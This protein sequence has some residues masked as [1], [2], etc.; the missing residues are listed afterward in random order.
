MKK[1]ILGVLMT[2][3]ILAGCSGNRRADYIEAMEQ[4]DRNDLMALHNWLGEH[5]D[6][7]DLFNVEK[8]YLDLDG[9]DIDQKGELDIDEVYFVRWDFHVEGEDERDLVITEVWD[10]ESFFLS[11]A[12]A[13]IL[14]GAADLR[15]D[16]LEDIV[17]FIRNPDYRNIFSLFTN[18]QAHYD[19]EGNAV[20]GHLVFSNLV[21]PDT[22]ESWAVEIEDTTLIITIYHS[23]T[24]LREIEEE[25][26]REEEEARAR[27]EEEARAREEA[28]RAREEERAARP[29]SGITRE[30]YELITMGM[31]RD[32]VQALIDRRATSE[33]TSE[34]MGTT[35]EIV[36]WMNSSNF[37]SI[38]V[39]F[40]NGRV[41][42]I[43]W[44]SL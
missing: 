26:I 13:T 36:T 16:H 21:V 2:L 7:Y 12:T 38:T 3:L 23:A 43:S 9:N 6:I 18:R 28:E 41:S 22:F 20:S 14:E 10:Y 42:S 19:T 34:F 5:E 32:E 24:R 29:P 31:T 35:T 33:T 15:A 30:V 1:K 17:E 40:T 25:R 11:K 8:M 44:F 37:N 27:E 4:L 39:M